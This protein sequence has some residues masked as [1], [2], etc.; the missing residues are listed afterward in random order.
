MMNY[1]EYIEFAA[2]R[3]IC[4][5]CIQRS[6]HIPLTKIVTF[7]RSDIVLNQSQF[8][9]NGTL[10]QID[11]NIVES[12]LALRDTSFEVNWLF[13][14]KNRNH[15]DSKRVSRRIGIILTQSGLPT[16]A[17]HPRSLSTGQLAYLLHQTRFHFQRYRYQRTL[18]KTLLALNAHR[19]AEI[20]SLKK[21][22]IDIEGRRIVLGMTKAGGTQYMPIPDNLVGPLERF[23]SHLDIEE[24]LF[25]KRNG[26]QWTSRTV[27]DVVKLDG[28]S[29]GISYS[30]PRRYRRTVGELMK[31]NGATLDKIGEFLR[32]A[33]IRTT[34]KYYAPDN[35]DACRETFLQ[36]HPFVST[37]DEF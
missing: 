26:A 8:F 6:M 12:Y 5:T 25:I 15:C 35:V 33:D 13:P 17:T 2:L 1:E 23:I 27:R 14:N 9:V 31:K 37:S 30:T 34:R 22:D 32:H 10:V 11:E 20:A 24:P 16:K 4:I 36:F 19:P 29:K 18:A 28:E 3:D 21:K 7:D